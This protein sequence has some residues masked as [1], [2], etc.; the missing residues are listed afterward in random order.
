[1]WLIDTA[2]QCALFS[3]AVKQTNKQT[4]KQIN[5]DLV[6]GLNQLLVLR[7]RPGE[8]SL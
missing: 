1:M 2:M 3:W 7:D 8:G 5:D 6:N 4:N